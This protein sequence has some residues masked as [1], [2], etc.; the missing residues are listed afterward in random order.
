MVQSDF[1]EDLNASFKSKMALSTSSE[2]VVDPFVLAINQVVNA[3]DKEAEKAAKKKQKK[4]DEKSRKRSRSSQVDSI[5]DSVQPVVSDAACDDSNWL[6][7]PAKIIKV[8]GKSEGGRVSKDLGVW[9]ISISRIPGMQHKFAVR[10]G[11]DPHCVYIWLRPGA[12]FEALINSLNDRFEVSEL[13]SEEIKK[14]VVSS[15]ERKS[16]SQKKE[17]KLLSPEQLL[18]FK[19]SC[20]DELRPKQRRRLNREIMLANDFH[21]TRNSLKA[22]IRTRQMRSTING[23]ASS[24]SSSF[25]DDEKS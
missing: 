9:N 23:D 16:I 21:H 15:I 7:R 24:S 17:A 5:F 11:P 8:G 12:D 22:S 14:A 1:I 10:R 25:T 2:A 18:Q 20:G 13:D 19:L 3:A 6:R 4:R